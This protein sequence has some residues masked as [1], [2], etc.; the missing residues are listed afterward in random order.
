M[1]VRS[2]FPGTVREIFPGNP[3]MRSFTELYETFRIHFDPVPA[4]M[5]EQDV[6]VIARPMSV[7]GTGKEH[8]PERIR[9]KIAGFDER[10]PG[11][12]GRP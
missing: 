10:I 8:L 5:P 11:I 7:N 3:A 4:F 2:E 12:R 1:I 6:P 9:K